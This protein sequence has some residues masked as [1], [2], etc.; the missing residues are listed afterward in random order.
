MED[1]QEDSDDSSSNSP[2]NPLVH[3]GNNSNTPLATNMTRFLNLINPINPFH[4][5]TS[6]NPIMILVPDLLTSDNYATWS[7]AMLRVLCA[8]NKLGFI[9][10]TIPQSIDLE[11]PLHD[12]WE[13]RNDMVVSWLQ[14]SIIPSIKSS[15]AFVDNARDIWLDLQDW[16]SQQNGPRIYQLK[17]TLASL[18]QETNTVSV[19][20]GKLKTI[21]DELS[22]YDSILVCNCGSIQILSYHY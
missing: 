9:T 18:L 17:K 7:C 12:L 2:H 14:N 3:S 15:I 22:I 11:D 1:F 13:H 8:K 6:D 21:P 4:L 19:Y 16:F 10:S 20:F 5:D